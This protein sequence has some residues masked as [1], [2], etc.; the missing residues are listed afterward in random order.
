MKTY[1]T[2]SFNQRLHS[3]LHLQQRQ[4]CNTE[5]ISDV[6]EGGFSLNRVLKMQGTLIGF[7]NYL[8][9]DTICL[10]QCLKQ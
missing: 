3:P 8:M 6:F 9:E 4:L 10:A 7:Q 1:M 5:N 2:G